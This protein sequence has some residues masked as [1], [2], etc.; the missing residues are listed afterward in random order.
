MRDLL[1]T[2]ANLIMPLSMG[3][4]GILHHLMIMAVSEVELVLL[5]RRRGVEGGDGVGVLHVW[6]ISV[7]ACHC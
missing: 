4:M 6:G 2:V 1:T 3:V 7:L 5:I